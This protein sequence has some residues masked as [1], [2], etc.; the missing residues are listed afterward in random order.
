MVDKPLTILHRILI[1][2]KHLDRLKKESKRANAC[3]LCSQIDMVWLSC[4][5][6]WSGKGLKV[7]TLMKDEEYRFFE[8]QGSL[9]V[10]RVFDYYLISALLLFNLVLL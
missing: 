4:I 7:S 6:T 8:F 1:C 3:Q 2:F 10:E 9:L 5:F